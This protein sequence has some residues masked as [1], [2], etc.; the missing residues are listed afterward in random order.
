[1]EAGIESVRSGGRVAWNTAVALVVLMLP[2]VAF[3]QNAVDGVAIQGDSKV[4][5]LSAFTTLIVTV[6]ELCEDYIFPVGA[7]VV[8]GGSL[9]SLY[10]E[11]DFTKFAIGLFVAIG[12][13]GTAFFMQS[14]IAAFAS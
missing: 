8:L 9:W 1:M 13:G 3:A 11:R 7:V 12:L 4:S 10:S 5:E 14:I 6:A 2:G